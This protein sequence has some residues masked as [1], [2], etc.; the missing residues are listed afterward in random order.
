MGLPLEGVMLISCPKCNTKIS[1]QAHVCPHCGFQMDTLIKC[2]DCGRLVLPDTAAC[3]DCGYPFPV[4]AAQA[5]VSSGTLADVGTDAGAG[6]SVHISSLAAELCPELVTAQPPRTGLAEGNNVSRG[7]KCVWWYEVH[8]F[9][10]GPTS[11]DDIYGRMLDGKLPSDVGVWREGCPGWAPAPKYVLFSRKGPSAA[12]VTKGNSL[13]E[14]TG[15]PPMVAKDGFTRYKY[16]YAY[17]K[18]EEASKFE[19]FSKKEYIQRQLAISQLFNS[20]AGVVFAVAL[21]VVCVW[22]IYNMLTR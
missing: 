9:V 8:G 11:A 20:L 6:T 18:D 22:F 15:R 14:S 13:P 17:L 3:P 4:G 19:M 7:T 1:D 16:Y 2:P 12:E 10:Y 21:I 5:S